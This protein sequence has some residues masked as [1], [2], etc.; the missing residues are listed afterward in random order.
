MHVRYNVMLRGAQ[1]ADPFHKCKTAY[2]TGISKDPVCGRDEAGC[3]S[4]Q[5]EWCRAGW[6]S[7]FQMEENAHGREVP[8]YVAPEETE[9]ACC[10][11]GESKE[12]EWIL[13]YSDEFGRLQC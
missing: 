12:P 11:R 7:N 13:T 5:G 8:T 3:K 2:P 10:Y 4:C 9:G 6:N 1:A